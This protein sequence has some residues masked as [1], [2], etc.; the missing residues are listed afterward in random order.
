MINKKTKN[1]LYTEILTLSNELSKEMNDQMSEEL[2]NAR[3][4]EEEKYIRDKYKSTFS[5][6]QRIITNATSVLLRNGV[7]F[8]TGMDNWKNAKNVI[9]TINGTKYEVSI[10]AIRTVLSTDAEKIL[11]SAEQPEIKNI[12]INLA[13]IAALDINQYRDRSVA[14][15]TYELKK[16]EE[17]TKSAEINN[18]EKNETNRPTIKEVRQQE[19]NTDEKEENKEKNSEIENKKTASQSAETNRINVQEKSQNQNKTIA[20]PADNGKTERVD[21]PNSQRNRQT[22][23]QPGKKNFEEHKETM[24]KVPVEYDMDIIDMDSDEQNVTFE[25]RPIPAE[26]KKKPESKKEPAQKKEELEIPDILGDVMKMLDLKDENDIKELD[27][28][29]KEEEKRQLEMN[30]DG[31]ET[32]SISASDLIMDI[33]NVKFT[34]KEDETKEEVYTLIIVPL[35]G[36]TDATSNLVPTYAFAK[37]GKEICL[38]ASSSL[39]RTSYQIMIGDE[40]F[41]IRGKWTTKGFS[42]LLYPQN[43]TD[44]KS[45]IQM[46]PI[47][48]SSP[49]NIGHNVIAVNQDILIHVMPL[50]SRNG[51]NGKVGLIICLEDKLDGKY[52]TCCTRDNAYADLT[53][54]RNTYRITASWSENRTLE[55]DITL[56]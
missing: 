31:I 52:V 21:L 11:D 43:L 40:A 9:L 48:P 38:N 25:K 34:D 5:H 51:A 12:E 2:D 53:Y 8:Y 16:N 35:S 26:T 20:K 28:K 27:K 6:C 24:T 44:R 30:F 54:K 45:A 50:S 55:T 47:H 10:Q 42:T 3:F 41:V 22:Q 15:F 32:T 4:D 39:T 14:S 56:L 1:A 18:K 36:M 23:A 7:P 13:P 33:Y 19:K 17:K 37:A 49:K 46:K 29:A